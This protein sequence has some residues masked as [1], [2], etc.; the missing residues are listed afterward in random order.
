[1]SPNK[2]DRVIYVCRLNVIRK[3]NHAY[4][5][6]FT[7]N[8]SVDTFSRLWLHEARDNNHSCL[9]MRA[10][11]PGSEQQSPSDAF[12]EWVAEPTSFPG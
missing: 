2:E 10:R 5:Y 7:E 12:L 1:M 4:E 9:D 3:R 11:N 6:L 8:S